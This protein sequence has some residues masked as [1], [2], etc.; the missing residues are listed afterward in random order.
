[1]DW[2]RV[3]RDGLAGTAILDLNGDDGR[4]TTLSLPRQGGNLMSRCCFHTYRVPGARLALS[5]LAVAV[6]GL[7]VAA[8]SSETPPA[9][10]SNGEVLVHDLPVAGP[11]EGYEVGQQ[12]PEFTLRLANDSTLTSTEIVE[13]GRPTFL[14][15]WA[16]T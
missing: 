4:T 10:D 8:C 11:A 3:S 12:A 7:L 9:A 14:F 5:A 13:S 1:M 15:F 2:R 16:T 6:L